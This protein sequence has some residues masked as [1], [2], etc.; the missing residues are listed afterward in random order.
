MPFLRPFAQLQHIAQDHDGFSV[1]P[2]P[3]QVF[4]ASRTEAG[5]AL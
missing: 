3:L 2:K 4:T 1:S 5:L